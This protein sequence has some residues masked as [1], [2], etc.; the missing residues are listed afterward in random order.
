[1]YNDKTTNFIFKLV[2]FHLANHR[3]NNI[4]LQANGLLSAEAQRATRQLWH[5]SQDSLGQPF[6]LAGGKA[7]IEMLVFCCPCLQQG[8]ERALGVSRSSTPDTRSTRVRFALTP[9]TKLVQSELS[10]VRLFS[11]SSDSSLLRQT[12]LFFVRLF[13]SSLDSSLLR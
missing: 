9:R 5:H 8:T 1:M 3:A 11:S 7:P 13:S 4:V 12:L 6:K 10:I 2:Q